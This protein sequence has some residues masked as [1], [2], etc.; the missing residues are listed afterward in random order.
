[1]SQE[2]NQKVAAF[3][4][5]DETLLAIDSSGIGFKVLK[6]NGYL[7]RGFML[8]MGLTLFAR[9]LGLVD[10][11]FMARVFLTFYKGRDLQE[12]IDSAQAF[13]DEY[14][15]PNLNPPVVKRLRWHQE[16]GHATIL[17]SGSID[18]YL[19]PVQEALDIDHL[20]CT[21]LE[22]DDSGLLS[23]RSLG[24]VCVGENKVEMA[25]ELAQAQNLDLEKSYAYGNSELDIP[26]LKSVGHPVAVNPD[27]GLA[28]FVREQQI[29]ILG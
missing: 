29:E 28:A 7:S 18:Y 1:M 15:Q 24:P 16:Q 5:F 11:R 12:F 9:K 23:G 10:D 19:K 17:I 2:I 26:I 4:D 13:F 27:S 22:K 20:L 14:L 25:V 6:E 21:H 3:F 8:K